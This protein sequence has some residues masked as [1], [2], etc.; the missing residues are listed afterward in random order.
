MAF[1]EKADAYIVKPFNPVELVELI[2]LHL[3]QQL[4]EMK[5][6]QKKVLEYIQNLLKY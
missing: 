4:D 3:N 5:Y 2:R 6:T 1:N